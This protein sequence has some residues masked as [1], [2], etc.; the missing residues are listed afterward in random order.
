[1]LAFGFGKSG[2]KQTSSVIG[3]NPPGFGVTISELVVP[4]IVN[5]VIDAS[6]FSPVVDVRGMS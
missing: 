2:C 4:S 1:M 3:L 6:T 5:D